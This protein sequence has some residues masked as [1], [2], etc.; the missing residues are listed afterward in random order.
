MTQQPSAS[1]RSARAAIGVLIFGLVVATMNLVDAS[2]ATA[3]GV[4]ITTKSTPLG[5]IVTDGRGRTA[6]LFTR[7]TT[8]H[9]NCTSSCARTWPR[10]ISSTVPH[11]AGGIAQSKLS[12]TSAHQVTY[13][14]HPLYFYV[15]DKAPS[16]TN[17]QSRSSFNGHWWVVSP[18]GNAGTG[19][20]LHLADT[21]LGSIVVGPK[22]HT[23]YMLSADSFNHSTCYASC[24]QNWPPL[25]TTGKPHVASGLNPSLLATAL[26]SGGS[27]QVTYNG[28][29]LYYF[30]GDTAAGQTN[31]EGAFAFNGY[32]YAVNSA[33]SSA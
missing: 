18:P 1:R 19:T 11:A 24:A 2:P 30:T 15:G 27:R 31:G 33:G 12:E 17:G 20:T 7:D 28:H 14:G 25:I 26:R 32:W 3:S 29:P 5:L 10:V 16:Q 21:S 8:K 4:T 13:N 6:Y 23:L 9:S 22:G